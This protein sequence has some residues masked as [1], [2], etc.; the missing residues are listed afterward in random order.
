[1]TN[2]VK[3]AYEPLNTPLVEQMRAF[4][5][6]VSPSWVIVDGL[7]V[8]G[9]MAI[10]AFE[11]MTG[12]MAPKRLMKE[13]GRKTWELQQQRHGSTSGFSRNFIQ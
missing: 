8:V 2:R 10:E 11:L 1:M 12:R 4:R 3:L 6:S 13:V 9:E 7:E 5:E